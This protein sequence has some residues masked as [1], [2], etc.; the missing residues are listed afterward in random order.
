MESREQV[1]I[2]KDSRIIF[3]TH[4]GFKSFV[5][6]KK[7]EVTEVTSEYYNQAKKNKK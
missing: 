1:V 5:Q 2:L 6:T 3:K 7:G 4:N